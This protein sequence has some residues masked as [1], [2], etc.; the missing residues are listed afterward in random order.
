MAKDKD[1]FRSGESTADFDARNMRDA[2]TRS[3][4][5]NPLTESGA[6][7][8]SRPRLNGEEGKIAEEE[9]RVAISHENLEFIET[10]RARVGCIFF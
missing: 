1:R 2:P 4:V 10:S 9:V 3:Y 5:F 8:K 6:R 7:S